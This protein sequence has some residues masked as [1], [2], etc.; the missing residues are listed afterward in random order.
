MR[1]TFFKSLQICC[2]VFV[3]SYLW[4]TWS[5]QGSFFAGD[6][7]HWSSV[8]NS[9]CAAHP[10][11]SPS[12]YG[13]G[14]RR[15]LWYQYF[16]PCRWRP[17]IF[18]PWLLLKPKQAGLLCGV[19]LQLNSRATLV[20]SAAV[21]VG[22]SALAYEKA[23]VAIQRRRLSGREGEESSGFAFSAT[24]QRQ[25]PIRTPVRSL[26]KWPTEYQYPDGVWSVVQFWPRVTG[27]FLTVA[28]LVGFD[29]SLRGGLRQPLT[30]ASGLESF[31]FISAQGF[32]KRNTMACVGARHKVGSDKMMAWC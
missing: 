32:K 4:L 18:C 24:F 11:V 15:G 31:M 21:S 9:S 8:R 14:Y 2:S 28:F 6:A 30:A 13:Y 27:R 5:I 22:S 17:L 23:G 10:P 7:S 26:R 29:W 19:L 25:F 12:R 1:V 3:S 20:K 16:R